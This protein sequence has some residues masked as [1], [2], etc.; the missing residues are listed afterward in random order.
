MNGK[1]AWW[2]EDD[3]CGSCLVPPL[4]QALLRHLAVIIHIFCQQPTRAE[5]CEMGDTVHFTEGKLRP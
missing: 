3:D 2:W 4:Y 5:L 1:A